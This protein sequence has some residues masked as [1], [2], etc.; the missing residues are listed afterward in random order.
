MKNILNELRQLNW[1]EYSIQF[2]LVLI[3][4]M[5][6]FNV[7]N[8][9]DY[10]QERRVEREYLESMVDEIKVDLSYFEAEVN[11]SEYNIKVYDKLLADHPQSIPVND[12]VVHVIYEF[13]H[14]SRIFSPMDITYT[15][16]KTSGKL[17]LIENKEIRKHIIML[18]HR[19]YEHIYRSEL[20]YNNRSK[21]HSYLSKYLQYDPAGQL[22]KVKYPEMIHYFRGEQQFNESKLSIYKFAVNTCNELIELINKE[23]EGRGNALSLFVADSE[24]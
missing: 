4:I 18:Y 11:N 23:L 16:M 2:F 19:Y 5:V 9:R 15:S 7:E 22:Y 3:S 24:G 20:E 6:A 8:F 10:Q 21:D 1:V 14:P 13:Y 17:E 12:S